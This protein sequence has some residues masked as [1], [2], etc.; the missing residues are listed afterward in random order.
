MA[1]PSMGHCGT[2]PLDFQLLTFLVTSEPHK[3]TLSLW[4]WTLCG[5]LHSKTTQAQSFCLLHEFHNVFVCHPFSFVPLLA[6]NPGDATDMIMMIWYDKTVHP[7]PVL[8]D[9]IWMDNGTGR[10]RQTGKVRGDSSVSESEENQGR[11]WDDQAD[12][13]RRPWETTFSTS[14]DD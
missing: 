2:C 8:M 13:E 10:V 14:A 12:D 5:C 9:Q 3:V 11:G 1:S 4:H 6:R 7:V